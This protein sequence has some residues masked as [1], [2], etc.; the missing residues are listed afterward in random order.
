MAQRIQAPNGEV[1]EFPDGMDDASIA[2]AMQKEFGGPQAP[3]QKTG[4]RPTFLQ[5]LAASPIGRL[6]NEMVVEPIGGIISL[7][8][9]A[10]PTPIVPTDRHL[11]GVQKFQDA[12]AAQENRPG[13]AQARATADARA[14]QRGAGGITDQVLAPLL[15]AAAGIAGLFT[16]G[17]NG[18][19]AEADGQKAAQ[20]GFQDR[21][22]IVSAIAQIGGGML[23]APSALRTST[24]VAE[25]LPAVPRLTPQ[26]QAV[27]RLRG[28][29]GQSKIAPDAAGL[30]A[31]QAAAGNKP[32]IAAEAIGKP[33][34]VDLGALARRDGETADAFAGLMRGRGEGAAERI[35]D[36]FAAA[37]GIEPSAAR[38]DIDAY[39]RG[40]QKRAH[41]LYQDAFSGGS[42]APLETQFRDA[43]TAATGK[44]GQI[45]KRLKY[46]EESHSGSLASRGAAGKD[47]RDEYMRLHKELQGAEADRVATLDAFK[48]AQSDITN[49]TPGAVWNPRIQQ[50]LD[51]KI[52]QQGIAEGLEVQRLEALASGQ[53]FDPTEYAITGMGQDGRPIVGNVPN[54]RLLDA[55]KRGLDEILN[56]YKDD[57]GRMKWTERSRAIDQV[58]RAY[59]NELDNLN[60]RYKAARTEAGDYLSAREAFDKGGKS[61]LNDN[62]T[63][64]QFA[65]MFAKNEGAQKQTFLGGIANNLYDLA[66]TDKL[67]GKAKMA[68]INSPRVKEKL[69]TVLGQEKA[70]AFLANL[71]TEANMMEFARK[72]VPGNG[73]PSMEYLEAT[74]Q[75]DGAAGAASDALQF[76]VDAIRGRSLTGAAVNMGLN[77]AQDAAAAYLTRGMPAPVRNALGELYMKS[78]GELADFLDSLPVLPPPN[79]RFKLQQS[80]NQNFQPYGLFGS[81]GYA[82]SGQGGR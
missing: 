71:R 3:Q 60:P 45:A 46:I 29:M 40:G 36:D 18:M 21:N 23:G 43:L 64:K 22:P 56:S 6:A 30:R 37:S 73:S 42:V 66:R 74:R 10:D 47:I 8:N 9:R 78:P 32:V 7:I 58:R 31:A 53:R 39:V 59:L 19:M 82:I 12:F 34:E 57:F 76:G 13:Y 5:N 65:E 63:E 75:Q 14:N 80:Y 26:Q 51:D 54:M 79:P 38:G 81:S 41:P 2:A 35:L 49:N 44:K 70:D 50:F 68:R 28:V 24:T 61:I 20:V 25:A 62:I 16:G 17:V 48:R 4:P 27:T 67:T 52:L 77:K 55:G 72:R 15:P 33:A 69:R 11:P 1:I